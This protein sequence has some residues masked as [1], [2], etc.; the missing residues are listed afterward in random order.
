MSFSPLSRAV[1]VTA[2]TC[3]L[4][5]Q[6]TAGTPNVP[7]IMLQNTANP[8]VMMPFAGL[9]TGCKIG[10]CTVHPGS[11]MLA[12]NMS[13][14]W[15]AIGGRRFD[16]ADS[17]GIE[18][19]IG[20]AIKDS[21]VP[22][23]EIF[24]LSK[25]G[26]GGLCWPLGYN[27]TIQQAMEIVKNYSV[28]SV[29][30]MLVHWPTNYG[31]CPIHGPKPSIPTTDPSCDSELK[32]YSE[33]EC[34]LSSWRGMLK[35]WKMGLAKAVGVSNFN[36]THLQEIDEAGLP[37]PAA[38]QCSF[39]PHHGPQHPGCTPGTKSETCGTL[40][41]YCQKNKIVFN[42]YSPF[43]GAGGA[44]SLLSD[45]RLVKIADGHNVSTSQVVLNWMWAL[46]IPTNPEAQ[47]KTY[48]E[49]NLNYF[50][51]YLTTD[52]LAVLNNF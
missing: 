46:Q 30:L 51:F 29:D 11:N 48:Q 10:G 42:S 5:M 24:I 38:N 14:Q 2:T 17:Y 35:V 23:E 37:L 41:D 39:S 49:L 22:R 36:T 27:E 32:T 52:E 34:R 45:P 31:P 9:G 15:L 12:Y 13:L 43:G 44:G 20:K 28:A 25:T 21:G 18:P 19:G 40:V 47:N 1:A 50:S 16:G 26:P 6:P 33:K 7:A 3:L 4:M 8:G